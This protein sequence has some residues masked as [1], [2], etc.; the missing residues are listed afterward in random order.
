[1]NLKDIKNWADETCKKDNVQLMAEGIQER[2]LTKV[3]AYLKAISERCNLIIMTTSKNDNFLND[4]EVYLK[5]IAE[6][7]G[8]VDSFK[9]QETTPTTTFDRKTSP[10]NK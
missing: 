9:K 7:G 8:N 4:I 6:Y 1:M 10:S 5:K 2:R 3:K